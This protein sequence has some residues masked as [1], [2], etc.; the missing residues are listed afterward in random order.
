MYLYVSKII[1]EMT[2]N[3]IIP[4][5]Q[6]D[7][8][9]YFV[10][11]NILL[12]I[13]LGLLI[14]SLLWP[15]SIYFFAFLE[16]TIV[17]GFLVLLT[18]INKPIKSI[19]NETLVILPGLWGAIIGVISN[20]PGLDAEVAFYVLAPLSYLIAFRFVRV[21]FLS[22]ALF[23]IKLFGVLNIS[24][25]F[26]LYFSEGGW[27]YDFLQHYTKFVIQYLDGFNKVYTLQATQLIFLLPV[28]L[29]DFYFKKNVLNFILI[30]ACLIMALLIAR[31]VILI[32]FCLSF[33]SFVLYSIY[34]KSNFKY[35]MLLFFSVIISLVV[36]AQISYFKIGKYTDAMFNSIPA[37]EPLEEVSSDLLKKPSFDFVPQSETSNKNN[38]TVL[39]WNEKPS[40]LELYDS[41]DNL[42]NSVKI[43]ERSESSDKAGAQIRN[44]QIQILIEKISTSPWLGSGLG[45]IIPNCIRSVEQPWRFEISYLTMAKDIGLLGVFLMSI[46]YLRWTLSVMSSSLDKS[47]SIPLLGGSLFF[48]ICSVTNPYIMSVENIFVYFIPYI[49]V[50][51]ER[52]KLKHADHSV[53]VNRR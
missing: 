44:S 37:F 27:L 52:S 38:Q 34:Q 46:V 50:Q 35:V 33:L 14:F 18:R 24:V 23:I 20:N 21:S 29:I 51:A 8:S 47:V 49:L 12:V 17:M 31:K 32:L 39:K 43:I 1:K 22:L 3:T 2:V 7:V 4:K 25:F 13:Q 9:Q 19:L 26:F 16:I 30:S 11:T 36:T 28:L 48:I 40:N 5:R 41:K 45:S 6:F 53:V 42:C 15:L 10:L